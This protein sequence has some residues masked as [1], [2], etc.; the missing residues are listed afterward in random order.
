MLKEYFDCAAL[1]GESDLDWWNRIYNTGPV[2]Y[3]IQAGEDYRDWWERVYDTP[4]T[5]SI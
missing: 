2:D 3:R 5:W 4:A 1:P